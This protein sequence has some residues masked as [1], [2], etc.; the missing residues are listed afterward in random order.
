LTYLPRQGDATASKLSRT[1]LLL[2]ESDEDL[3]A[4]SSDYVLSFGSIWTAGDFHGLFGDSFRG[5]T[6]QFPGTARFHCRR[7]QAG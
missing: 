1:L 5:A 6:I 4:I 3:N 7:L 2:A